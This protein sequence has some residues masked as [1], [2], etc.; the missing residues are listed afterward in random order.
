MEEGVLRHQ[1]ALVTGGSKGI[2][3]G[4]AQRLVKAGASIVIVARNPADLDDAAATL[5][6]DATADQEIRVHACD[7]SSPE[8]VPDLFA[9]VRTEIGVPNIVIANAGSGRLTPFLDLTVD[10]WRATID[11]NLTGTF[12]CVQQAAR[13]MVTLGSAAN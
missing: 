2:G 11:L 9:S 4:I 8:E 6:A 1:L 5:R 10:D 12:L 3:F 7:V 13:G